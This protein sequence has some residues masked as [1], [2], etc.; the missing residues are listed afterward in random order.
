MMSVVVFSSGGENMGIA[1]ITKAAT[2]VPA[3]DG[4]LYYKG[5][6]ECTSGSGVGYVFGTG[7]ITYVN[8]AT[9]E[10]DWRGTAECVPDTPAKITMNIDVA[11]S[12]L[13]HI[14]LGNMYPM[15]SSTKVSINGDTPFSFDKSSSA[16]SLERWDSIGLHN[17]NKGVNIIELTANGRGY[18][19]IDTI[20][21]SKDYTE[22]TPKPLLAQGVADDITIIYKPL[23][24]SNKL[25]LPDVDDSYNVEIEHVSPEGIIDKDGNIVR[26]Q[27][28]TD[29]TV[30]FKVTSKDNPSDIGY[31]KPLN[32]EI[33]APYTVKDGDL[34][35]AKEE[36]KC[37]NRGFFVHYVPHLTSGYNGTIHD[38]DELANTFDAQQFANDME[39]MGIEYVVFT[40]WHARMLTLFP[41]ETNKRWR[42][43]RRSVPQNKSYSDRDV[44]RD[45]IDALKPKGIDLYLYAHPTDGHDFI[46]R[47]EGDNLYEDQLLTGFNDSTVW[48]EYINELY[49]EMCKRYGTDIKGIWNDGV[50][51]KIDY[52]RL[53]KTSRAYNPEMIIIENAGTG[54]KSNFAGVRGLGDFD[55]WEISDVEGAVGSLSL[56]SINPNVKSDDAKMW[57]ASKSQVALILGD[58][59]WSKD[60]NSPEYAPEDNQNDSRYTAENLYLYNVLLASVSPAGG[61][62]YSSGCGNGSNSDYEGGD[63]WGGGCEG[64]GNIFET[65]KKVNDIIKPVEE[66]IKNVKPG[67]AYA[68]KEM[69]WLSQYDW[70]VS[71]ESV[72][73]KYIYLHV[74]N[75]PE[76]RTLKLDNTADGSVLDDKAVILNSE[77]CVD[78]VKTQS[79]YELTLP[80]NCEWDELDTVVRVERSY[81]NLVYKDGR[82]NVTQLKEPCSLVVVS[83]DNHDVMNEIKL[84]DITQD[85]S[86]NMDELEFDAGKVKAFLWDMSSVKPLSNCIEFEI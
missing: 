65:M 86:I 33:T 76:G 78:I 62:L 28:D 82:I 54:R 41:S 73:G 24:E 36:F 70:G 67:E 46:D 34:E 16:G 21:I 13:Y 6:S 50:N 74:V 19:R 81:N 32:V 58:G 2:A 63:I 22:P 31:T 15:I 79:G 64:G 75:K 30:I 39:E 56:T 37:K 45:L 10:S 7:G 23:R 71:T 5:S 57:P 25:T 51:S 52:S 61:L 42:D 14:E 29:I 48:N 83:Y 20:A 77:I 26:P 85:N 9:L 3:E 35:K 4:K 43:D 55:C 68:T 84:F 53:K 47:G 66:S 80:E 59:W 27:N 49:D 8:G 11:E 17:L 18:I 69:T 44:I 38:I 72:D 40:V 12:G 1:E 60:V